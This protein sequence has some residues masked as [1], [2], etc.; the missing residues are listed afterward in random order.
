M[1][2][3]FHGSEEAFRSLASKA[4]ETNAEILVIC[5][6]ITHFGSLQ[7]ARYLLSLLVGLRLPVLFVPGNCDPPSL[8]AVEVE[9][10]I[11]IHGSFRSYNDVTFFGFGGGP[12]SPFDTPFE[13]TEEEMTDFFSRKADEAVVNQRFILVSHTPPKDTRLDRI[14]SGRHVGSR[15]VRRFIEERKP[16]A[17]FCG[18]IHEA[19]GVDKIGETIVVNPGPARH[20]C[21]ALVSVNDEIK[22]EVDYM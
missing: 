4:E 18:H 19:R 13:M 14:Y 15:S 12:I 7:D 11:C 2:T 20:G 3:D 21:Y 10:A 17:V 5:G 8:A 6:D 1:G 9:G 22:V 16:S